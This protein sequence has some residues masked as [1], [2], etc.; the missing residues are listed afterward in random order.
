MESTRNPFRTPL[1][2]GNSPLCACG[3]GARTSTVRTEYILGHRPPAKSPSQRLWEKIDKRGSGECWPWMAHVHRNG[4][5][6]FIPQNKDGVRVMVH[7]YA[8]EELVGPI[9]DG[10][11]IDHLCKNRACCNPAHMEPVTQGENAIRG[12]GAKAGVAARR[13]NAEVGCRR[14][15][16][17][18]PEH[19]FK[20]PKGNWRCRTCDRLR[21]ANK[22]RAGIKE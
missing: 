18:T 21:Q 16:P 1:P 6:T 3:C 7:R 11:T 5:A 10:L 15:H 8:Y 12:G 9:P 4:Y 19:A 14:G 13:A 2:R 22:R 17:R 20:T